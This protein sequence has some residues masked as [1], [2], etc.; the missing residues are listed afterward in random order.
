MYVY[1][2]NVLGQQTVRKLPIFQIVKLYLYVYFVAPVE[3]RPVMK[4][5]FRNPLDK[6]PTE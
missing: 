5:F 6:R 3:Q 1:I 2:K 4:L